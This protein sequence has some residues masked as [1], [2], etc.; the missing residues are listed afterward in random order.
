MSSMLG[1][2]SGSV[3]FSLLMLA[4]ADHALRPRRGMADLRAQGVWP[5]AV[6]PVIYGGLTLVEFGVGAGGLWALLV[7]GSSRLATSAL[8]AAAAMYLMF[9]LYALALLHWRPAA[10]CGCSTRQTDVSVWTVVRASVL[11]GVCALSLAA[12]GP[13]G[14]WTGQWSQSATVVLI[15]VSFATIIWEIPD[16]MSNRHLNRGTP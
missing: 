14:T 15:I 5:V 8:Y 7:D 3:A 13:A 2:V 4:G 16:A 12:G 10:P 1:F 11:L 6:V 9:A